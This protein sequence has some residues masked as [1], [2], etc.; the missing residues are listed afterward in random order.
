MGLF[1]SDKNSHEKAKEKV[2]ELSKKLREESRQL[3]R[4]IHAIEREE[5][6]TIQMIKQAAKKNQMD[7]CKIS[8]QS[9]ARSKKAKSRI[10]ASKAQI[11]SII[12]QMKNQVA[13]MKLAGS[14]KSSTDVMKAM[15]NLVK[16]PELQKTMTALSKEMMKAGIIDELV[17]DSLDSVL[18]TD[19]AD[20]DQVAD[21][22]VEKIIFE[23]T[24]GKLKDLPEV[25][26][27][28]LSTDRGAA[29][30]ISD[31]EEEPLEDMTKRLEAL[32]S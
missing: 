16:L 3:D 24:Q 20:I 1:G 17:Q 18:D 22:E 7:V 25:G 23:I 21:A 4:Q 30:A 29:A 5:Q 31:D 2:N 15:S 19:N 26:T 11:N 14:I 27:S 32:R 28:T 10:Y 12:M 9:L 6:K 13:Q 8:A